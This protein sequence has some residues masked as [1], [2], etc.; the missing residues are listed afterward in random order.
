MKCK[1]CNM[2]FGLM[3]YARHLFNPIDCETGEN[4]L[5]CKGTK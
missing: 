1:R 3:A 2:E 4:T 5:E